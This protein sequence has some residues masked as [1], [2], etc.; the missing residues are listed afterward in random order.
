M[1]WVVEEIILLGVLFLIW[2]GAVWQLVDEVVVRR[3]SRK[4]R[5]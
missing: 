4:E 3:R 1:I 5:G 2:L